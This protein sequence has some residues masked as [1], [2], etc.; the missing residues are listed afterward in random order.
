M[1]PNELGEFLRARRAMVA[2]DLIA[3]GDARPRRVPG[4]RREEVARLAGLSTDYYTRLEQGRHRSPSDGVLAGLAEALQLDPSARQHLF[5]LA[6]AAAG[7]VRGQ[8]SAAA[9]QRVRPSLYQLLDAVD[10]PAFVRGRRTEV[11]AMNPLGAEVLH[12]FLAEPVRQRQ[13]VRWALLDPEARSRYRDWESVVSGMVGTLRMDAGRHPDDP[14]LKELVGDLAVNSPEFR[15]WWAE[16][17]VVE[18]TAGIKNLHHPVVGDLTVDYEALDV[19]G[20]ED[21]TLFIYTARPGS[22]THDRLAQLRELLLERQTRR[23][24][25]GRTPKGVDTGAIAG[26]VSLT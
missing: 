18:R 3:L 1:P 11:L 8:R 6:R 7:D 22:P 12:D 13:L 14:L 16:Q 9:V 2:P 19:A 25:A 23:E 24:T 4:L 20:E 5:S 21:Q 15:T 10:L 17:R 26:K